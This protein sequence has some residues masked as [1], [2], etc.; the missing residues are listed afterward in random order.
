[1]SRS[2]EEA[3]RCERVTVQYSRSRGGGGIVA[4]EDVDLRVERGEV[5]GVVGESGSGKSTLLRVLLGLQQI[6]GG[7]A[8]VAG[9]SVDRMRQDRRLLGRTVGAVFQ[10]PKS[11]VN[12]RMTVE[13]ALRDP[14]E[15]QHRGSVEAEA[16]VGLLEAVGLDSALLKRRARSLSGGQLQRVAIAR[17]L[18]LR[19]ML[20]LADEP[21][22]ALDVSVQAQILNTLESLH[23]E[24]GFAMVIVS[25]DLRVIRHVADRVLVMK[26]GVV[27]EQ[28]SARRL[29]DYPRQA[30]T[31]QL[32]EASKGLVSW[33][34][35]QLG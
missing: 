6:H 28:G 7:R 31:R 9:V 5:V 18:S 12:P 25:H 23:A 21:T 22:S 13:Q 26:S 1:M 2:Q 19:P 30:Y 11:S 4:L 15:V 24:Y 32:V 35:R 10:D 3:V 33:Y 8:C 20:L 34:G 14:F 17:A 16:I 29:Y 27:V